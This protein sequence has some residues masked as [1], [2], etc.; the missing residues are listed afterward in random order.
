MGKVDLS[1]AK[2][3][4]PG[5]LRLIID[6]VHLNGEED[7]DKEVGSLHD[8]RNLIE[9]NLTPYQRGMLP[10]QLNDLLGGTW[11]EKLLHGKVYDTII[12]DAGKNLYFVNLKKIER[13][14]KKINN[15]ISNFSKAQD[16]YTSNQS[17]PSLKLLNNLAHAINGRL[18][19]LGDGSVREYDKE[20]ERI[21]SGMVRKE[22]RNHKRV[23]KY[24]P[25]YNRF[26]DFY[27]IVQN[28]GNN[29]VDFDEDG[30][31]I[32]YALGKNPHKE[33]SNDPNRKFHNVA[34]LNAL[35]RTTN[36]YLK[37]AGKEPVKSFDSEMFS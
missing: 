14:Q 9:G 2:A 35:A 13:P 8:Y 27:N 25:L 34:W 26:L 20:I 10:G 36:K 15:Y 21:E 29:I 28:K 12:Y 24:L 30:N 19:V 7:L 1:N 23:D 33:K 3:S 6:K 5:V 22:Q 18:K 32:K 4:K 16:I 31:I 11:D 37:R 17:L